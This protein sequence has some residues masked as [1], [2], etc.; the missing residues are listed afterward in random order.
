MT[1]P[2]LHKWQFSLR[3]AFLVTALVGLC[4]PTILVPA[5]VRARRRQTLIG[6]VNGWSC[7][8]TIGGVDVVTDV[9]VKSLLQMHGIESFSYGSVVY[10]VCV[11]S[12]RHSRAI[13]VIR[14]D[15]KQRSYWI[16]L[17]TITK[18]EQYEAADNWK[19]SEPRIEYEELILK[20]D[21]NGELRAVL[22]SNLV[23]RLTD[24]LP[25]VRRIRSLKREYL[26][27]NSP[28]ETRVAH[29]IEIELAEDLADTSCGERLQFL[30]WDQGRQIEYVGGNG[31]T[32]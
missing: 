19:V 28:R 4:I 24:D 14:E 20:K 11:P 9:H 8:A 31:N 3:L 30:V 12:D 17:H 2:H 27:V 7:V 6:P 29:E 23:S 15:L 25:Y 21:A 1:N 32:P 16:T 22:K 13:D 10:A 18:D 26:D 5:L